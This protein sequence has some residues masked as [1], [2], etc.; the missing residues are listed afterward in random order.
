MSFR[1]SLLEART[2]DA[3]TVPDS[4]CYPHWLTHPADLHLDGRRE[5]QAVYWKQ[6]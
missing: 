3:L 1:Y 4:D 2:K 5:V 6:I